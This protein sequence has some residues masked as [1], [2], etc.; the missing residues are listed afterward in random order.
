MLGHGALPVARLGEARVQRQ[1]HSV[2]QLL[3]TDRNEGLVELPHRRLVAIDP[4]EPDTEEPVAVLL[5]A[6]A[7]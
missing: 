1:A 6:E 2:S 3:P 4:V 7:P 5:V